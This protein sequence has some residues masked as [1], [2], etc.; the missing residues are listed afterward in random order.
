MIPTIQEVKEAVEKSQ[1]ISKFHPEGNEY[2]EAYKTLLA[3]AQA[4]FDV[5]GLEEKEIIDPKD[6]KFDNDDYVCNV[7]KEGYNQAKRE[8]RLYIAE[9]LSWLPKEINR[10]IVELTIKDKKEHL[11]IPQ[12]RDVANRIKELFGVK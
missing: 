3:L 1:T 12:Q 2:T 9:K 7:Y 8:D 11:T 5:E 6:S 10:F 4:Y